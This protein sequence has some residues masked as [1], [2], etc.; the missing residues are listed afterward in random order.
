MV[1]K[2]LCGEYIKGLSFDRYDNYLLRGIENLEDF[3]LETQKNYRNKS[4]FSKGYHYFLE[5]QGYKRKLK[6]IPKDK[7]ILVNNSFSSSYKYISKLKNKKVVIV[8]DLFHL[9]VFKT[10]KNLLKKL[11][12]YFTFNFKIVKRLN[13]FDK[14]IAISNTTKEDLIKFGVKENKIIVVYNGI[15]LEKF[16]PNKKA[17]VQYKNYIV[18]VG[19]EG[20]RKNTSGIIKAFKLLKKDFPKLKL[21]KIG[22]V[23]TTRRENTLK[24]IK[25]H[26]LEIGKD[27]IFT[28]FVSD[29]KLTAYYSKA[30][31]LLFPSFKEG[32]GFPIVEA[33]ACGCP[34]I[35]SN[36][37]P[38]NELVPNK[39]FTVNP[40]NTK[41]IYETCKKLIS[42]KK[43]RTAISK[44]GIK[45]SKKFDWK[46]TTKKIGGVLDEI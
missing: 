1:G 18:S 37:G 32:F 46:N 2:V 31:F 22:K 43:L 38:M 36:F 21:I 11:L 10:E 14:I 4:F 8:H 19:D 34:V 30:L 26:K 9:S 25:E 41:E 45:H 17:K 15:D 27:V 33:E 42:D 13:K 40:R 6:K 7:I 29:E 3:R 20:G 39:K 12:F 44:D 5:I 35:T 23:R 16:K 24:L 28:G